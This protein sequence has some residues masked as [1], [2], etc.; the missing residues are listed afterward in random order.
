VPFLVE[1]PRWLLLEDRQQEAQ[2][3]LSRLFAQPADHPDVEQ[4]LRVMTETIAREKAEGKMGWGEIFHNGPQQ[5]FRRILLGA[6]A[7]FM[8]QIGGVNVVVL[9]PPI[10]QRF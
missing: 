3:V 5:T 7:S 4:A 10:I 8:Q 1:S 9:T 6:G 2:G